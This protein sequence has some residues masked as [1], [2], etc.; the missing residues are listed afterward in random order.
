LTN[1][2]EFET[3]AVI[4]GKASADL[5]FPIPFAPEL[6]FSEFNSTVADMKNSVAVCALHVIQTS[7]KDSCKH[8]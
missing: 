6:H 4:A 8:S 1:K 3:K 7:F 5:V 2:E